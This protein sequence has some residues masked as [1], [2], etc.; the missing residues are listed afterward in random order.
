[1]KWLADITVICIVE[2]W[3]YL[4]FVLDFFFHLVVSWAMDSQR[5]EAL[6]ESALEMAL[7]RRYPNTSLLHHSDRGS[8][9]TSQGYRAKLA[10]EG[11]IVSL[12]R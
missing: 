3:L 6:V 4:A 5:D 10:Q 8:Q 7:S 1:M 2:G 11:I 9:Y 12:R